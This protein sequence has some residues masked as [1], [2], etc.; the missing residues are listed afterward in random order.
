MYREQ[1][2]KIDEESLPAPMTYD[3]TLEEGYIENGAFW[4]VVERWKL[5]NTKYF[6]EFLFS[7]YQE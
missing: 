5:Q 6:V 3:D 1:M 2:E 4:K 7:I